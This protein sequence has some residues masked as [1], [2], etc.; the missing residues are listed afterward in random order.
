LKQNL[1]ASTLRKKQ[2]QRDSEI[3]GI[4]QEMTKSENIKKDS[5]LIKKINK[6]LDKHNETNT[7]DIIHYNSWL[8]SK[9]LK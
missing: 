2:H 6:F 5:R 9:N 8:K 7:N 3:I 4:I 1:F